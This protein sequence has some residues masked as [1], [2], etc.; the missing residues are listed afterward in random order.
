MTGYDLMRR[1]LVGI[2]AVAGACASAPSTNVMRLDPAPHRARP[3]EDVA[4]LEALPDG[5][6]YT[7]LARIE[8]SDACME[9]ERAAMVARVRKEAAAL[10]ADAIV[11]ERTTTRRGT[12]GA[13]ALFGRLS[14]CDERVVAGTAI[15]YAAPPARE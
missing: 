9:Q 7:S 11:V 3:A 5:R 10:G 2:L 4:V 12:S 14:R 1:L 15:V 6:A 8:V 13:G